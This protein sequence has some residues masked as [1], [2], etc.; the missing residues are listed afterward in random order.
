MV[1]L[2][3][4][5]SRKLCEKSKKIQAGGTG[6]TQRLKVITVDGTTIYMD[7]GMG[8]KIYDVDGNEYIDYYLDYGPLI[9]GHAH[10]AIVEAIKKQLEKGT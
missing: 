7:R 9:N 8:S 10:P 6:S 2:K 5:K 1:G 4:E 3:L